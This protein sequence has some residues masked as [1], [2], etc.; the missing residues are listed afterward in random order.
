MILNRK[1]MLIKF[2]I[3]Y[4]FFFFSCTNKI[5]DQKFTLYFEDVKYNNEVNTLA[6]NND[7]LKNYYLLGGYSIDRNNDGEF[8][9]VHLENVLKKKIPYFN[10]SSLLVLD[11]EGIY[12]D[13]IIHY[14]FDHSRFKLS[15]KKYIDLVH[16]IKSIRPYLKI[17]VYGIPFRNYNPSIKDIDSYK[18]FFPLLELCD[19]ITPSMYI[20]HSTTF[21]LDDEGDFGKGIKI[22]LDISEQLNIPLI[23]FV[24][25]VYYPDRRDG[26]K[27]VNRTGLIFKNI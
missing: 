15:L 21:Y 3:S 26:L 24:W 16:F 4:C 9:R 19:V 12:F 1:I 20:P 22:G 10:D 14:P 18:K 7:F 13:K 11:W 25:N 6:S 27:N 8:D 2:F 23:P 5:F 17:G